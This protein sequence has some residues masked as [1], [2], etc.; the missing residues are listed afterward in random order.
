MLPRAFYCTIL[1]VK[2]AA[3]TILMTGIIKWADGED[4]EDG[5][6]GGSDDDD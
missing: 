4:D 1:N 2:I 3:I 5:G 6:R